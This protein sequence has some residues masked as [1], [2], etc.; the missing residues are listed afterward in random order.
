MV[1][2]L[3]E[4]AFYKKSSNQKAFRGRKAS[5]FNLVEFVREIATEQGG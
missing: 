5:L 3:A 2:L 4:G 1:T